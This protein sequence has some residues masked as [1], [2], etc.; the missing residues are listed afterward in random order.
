MTLIVL[1]LHIIIDT[2]FGLYVLNRLKEKHLS[3]FVLVQA[4]AIGMF[5]ETLFIG[6][7]SYL[8]VSILIGF[9]SFSILSI[10]AFSLMIKQSV[11]S[12][13]WQ[14]TLFH[15]R[16]QIG[17]VLLLAVITEKLAWSILN[18]AK[19]PVF[20]DD[21]LNH[22]SG[23]GRALLSG[24]N[25][26]WDPTSPYF[27]GKVFGHEEYPLFLSIWR[28]TNTALLGTP[29]GASERA[30]GFIM[31]VFVGVTVLYWIHQVTGKRWLGIAGGAII[32]SLPLQA[33]HMTAGYA[34]I[35]I[36]AYLI[37]AFWAIMNN[38]FVLAGIF[39][40]A[41]IWSKNE[42]L[43]LFVPCL[44]F[45]LGF[46]LLLTP[47][48][49][50]LEKVK[51]ILIYTFTWLLAISPWLLFKLTHGI[52]FT[53][54]GNQDI[55]YVEGAFSLFYKAMFAAPSSGILWIFLLLAIALG[56]RQIFQNKELLSILSGA[57]IVLLM[58]LFVFTC[59]G[60]YPFLENQ[61]TIH[62][63]LL[64]IAPVFVILAVLAL[65]QSKQ[66]PI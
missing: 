21:A 39:T 47:G 45:S 46:R 24:V 3:L 27:M 53:I 65:G 8:G 14:D 32:L 26:S 64:Q 16:I 20:F 57:I 49:N 58:M 43:V 52:G 9:I 35:F 31:A 5:V 63:S 50:L 60:A 29:N 22:W 15:G 66:S 18:L 30:D 44:L 23:R 42:G 4:A 11:G 56:S 37:L 62:R 36:Q 2:L 6:I 10:A 7:L 33:W 17:E 13:K 59:T 48:L 51:S 12:L 19:L 1:I 41:L 54:P 55:G 34:E 25:W 28:A 38:R 40:A 61:M